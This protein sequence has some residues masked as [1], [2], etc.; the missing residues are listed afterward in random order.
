MFYSVLFPT[1]ESA[2]RPRR[3]TAPEAFSDLQLDVIMKRGLQ[4]LT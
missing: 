1:E 4:F 2:A 3:K